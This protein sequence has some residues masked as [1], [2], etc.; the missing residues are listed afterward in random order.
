MIGYIRG[1]V[2]ALFKDACFLEA[3]G[4]G[5]RI[6][7]SDKTRQRLSN[8]EEAKLLTYMAVRED[9]ILLYGFLGQEEYDL[10]LVLLSVSKIGPKVA[11]GI[12]SSM[13]PAQF[14]GAVKAQNVSRLTKLPGIGK[15]TAERLLVELKDKVGAFASEDMEGAVETETPKDDGITGEAV[16]AL[17]SLGYEMEE[18][19]PVLRK[20]AG[21][22][23]TVSALVS[24]ALREFARNRE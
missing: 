10:F 19:T 5:Y 14:V 21:S 16:R 24:A 6:F 7:I 20:L 8:G 1:K 13:D 15:K 23:T 4:I 11:M 2:T 12:L 17:M 9:A 22:Y 3:G 18:I